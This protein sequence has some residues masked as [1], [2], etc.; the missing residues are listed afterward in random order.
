MASR[1]E[2]R[3]IR[4]SLFWR[5]YAT[6][7]VSVLIFA[8]LVGALVFTLTSRWNEEQVAALVDRAQ[9]AGAPLAD[10]LA[11][12]DMATL[13]REL[14]QLE[15]ALESHVLLYP[16]A[17]GRRFDKPIGHGAHGRPP[18]LPPLDKR[19]LR[20]LRRG[21]PVVRRH[22]T[23]PPTI[24]LALFEHG[25]FPGE[26]VEL[27]DRDRP[28]DRAQR[29]GG[30]LI[31]VVIIEPEAR[32]RRMLLVLGGLLLLAL[33]GGAWPLARSLSSRLAKLERSTEALARG[34]LSHRAE[35]AAEPRDEIDRLADSFNEMATRLEAL[36]N[37]QRTLLAN[38]SHELRTPIA[39]TKVLVE[40]L[41]ER[42]ESMGAAERSGEPVDR[43]DL[44]RLERGFEEIG[45]DLGEVEALIKDLLTSG[46]LELGRE[47]ALALETVALA[48]LCAHA[49][50]R[51]DARVDCP[52]TLEL[53]GDRML[54]ERLLRNLLANA[55]RACP[56]GEID[57]RARREADEIVIEVEDEGPGIPADK[58][59]EIFEPFTRLDSARARDHGG[60]GL[61]LYLCRQIAE[62]H[63][64]SIHASDRADGRRGAR[65]VI[66]LAP[67]NPTSKP[68]SSSSSATR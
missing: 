47:G 51:F 14:D 54:L 20:R 35:T 27:E 61:G 57:I 10:A 68:S 58:R 11:T 2:P 34:E 60:V 50:S 18:P 5:I 30:R 26:G 66:R 42:L 65:F 6:F 46:R 13:E 56:T 63:G 19:Q 40:I 12:R 39:R 4:A 28:D 38:V 45:E 7:M 55:R 64:G 62:A 37:G 48:Q 59:S 23:A 8:V 41:G 43:E 52:A 53:D 29:P 25:F 22:G 31:A 49:A 67:C 16:R 44:A 3:A 36:V 21:Q 33:A 15:A 17:R 32:P 1:S 24:T 9:P